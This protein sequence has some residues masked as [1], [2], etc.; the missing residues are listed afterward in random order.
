MCEDM[1]Q[2]CLTHTCDDAYLCARHVWDASAA[3]VGLVQPL[4]GGAA[5]VILRALPRLSLLQR[6]PKG[7][8]GVQQNDRSLMTEV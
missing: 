6:L 8:K 4:A 5:T 3:D 2:P 7:E 1:M